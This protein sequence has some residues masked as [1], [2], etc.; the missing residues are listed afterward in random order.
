M[1]SIVA[2]LSTKPLRR[3]CVAPRRR[4]TELE[5]MRLADQMVEDN[6]KKG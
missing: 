2:S 1:E 5:A 6:V 3:A 4:I